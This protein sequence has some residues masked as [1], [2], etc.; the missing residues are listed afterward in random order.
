M[1]AAVDVSVLIPVLNEAGIIGDTTTGMLAQRFDGEI[2]FLFLDGG[3]S[4]ATK[5]ILET[6]AAADE[7]VKVLD[8]PGKRQ[9]RALNIGLREAR[10]EFVARMDAHTYYPPDYVAA[11]VRRLNRGDIACVGGPQ[12]PLGVGT[13]SRRV[14]VAMRS[15][16][17]VGGAV[18]RR[19]LSEEIEV[20]TAFTGIWRKRTVEDLGGWDEEALVNE[21]GELA[22]RIRAE[23]GRIVCIPEMAAQCITRDSLPGLGKQYYRYGWDRMRTLRRHPDAMRRS[24]VLPPALTLTAAAA[25]L[26]SRAGGRMARLA[27]ACYGAAL[28]WEAV[29]LSDRGRERDGVFAPL[30]LAVMH[31][32]WGVGFLK[33]CFSHGPPWRALVALVSP[34]SAPAPSDR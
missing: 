4:D 21:D 27:L 32:G 20:D 25:A 9:C 31:F 30:V 17:G 8:N 28:G 18:F 11:G 7:R 15:P 29:R 24:H 13:W 2:E 33:G 3:S 5:E 26:P 6:L 34:R 14:A 12:L 19:N 1:P 10:G 16:L 22:A 23:G